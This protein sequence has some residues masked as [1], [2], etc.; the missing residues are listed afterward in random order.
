[1][2]KH[3]ITS[4]IKECLNNPDQSL[5]DELIANLGETFD[6]VVDK[7]IDGDGVGN[8]AFVKIITAFADLLSDG[9]GDEIDKEYWLRRM[10][11]QYCSDRYLLRVTVQAY[12]QK[13]QE[14]LNSF[15]QYE[16][17]V[18]HAFAVW[19]QE[20]QTHDVEHRIADKIITINEAAEKGRSKKKAF[21]ARVKAERQFAEAIQVCT[22]YFKK[23]QISETKILTRTGRSVS[24]ERRGVSHFID[25]CDQE[26]N[27]Q[28]S[29]GDSKHRGLGKDMLRKVYQYLSDNPPP[30]S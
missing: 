6:A 7:F 21:A 29:G 16:D 25:Y 2:D 15:S 9:D 22:P 3:E 19:E 26:I 14:L 13:I 12:E 27:F 11:C 18:G 20:N 10:M 5:E 17:K 28:V 24:V 8:P 4:F 23:F 30:K 1:M